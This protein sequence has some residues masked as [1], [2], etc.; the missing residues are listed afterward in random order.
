MLP[1]ERKR[2]PSEKRSYFYY[3][4]PRGRDGRDEGCNHNRYYPAVS[5]EEQVWEEVYLFLL[6]PE[7]MRRGL[8][9]LVLAE[10]QGD[11]ELDAAFAHWTDMLSKTGA[12]M[13]RLLDLYLEGHLGKGRYDERVRTLEAEAQNARG[14]LERLWARWQMIPRPQSDMEELVE[15]YAETLPDDLAS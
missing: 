11:R 3:I 4:C 14:E 13:D 2:R 7:R 5:L 12:K 1:R 6:D 15:S 10:S 9:Q 8:E